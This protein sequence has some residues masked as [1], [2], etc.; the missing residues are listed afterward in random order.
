MAQKGFARAKRKLPIGAQYQASGLVESHQRTV[1]ASIVVVLE[2][3]IG[4]H[5]VRHWTSDLLRPG[6]RAQE[7]ESVAKPVLQ[8]DLHGMI[9]GRNVANV[10]RQYAVEL[11][12]G[13]QQLSSSHLRLAQWPHFD[14][15]SKRIGDLFEQGWPESEIS[16]GQLIQLFV[17]GE[18]GA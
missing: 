2:T 10:P 15:R 16:V 1:R 17:H 5:R 13:P 9:D 12:I 18:A 7:R 8:L 3:R 4:D 6:E 14:I 11:G